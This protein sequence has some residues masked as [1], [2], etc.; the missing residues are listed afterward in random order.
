MNAAAAAATVA[1]SNMKSSIITAV[2]CV[3]I[4][5]DPRETGLLV[6]YVLSFFDCFLCDVPLRCMTTNVENE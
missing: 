4:V 1:A 2:G 3:F 6:H 5:L